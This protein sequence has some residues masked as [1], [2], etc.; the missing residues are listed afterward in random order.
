MDSRFCTLGAYSDPV[1]SKAD[2]DHVLQL[3]GY[4]IYSGKPN[5]LCKNT[6][7][8][9][10]GDQGYIRIERGTNTFDI[11]EYVA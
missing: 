9:T 5:L 4:S 10:W 6:W 2:I 8:A 1:C 7:G 11:A 3:V